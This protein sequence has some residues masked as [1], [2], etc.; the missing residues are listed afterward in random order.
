MHIL[1]QPGY[2]EQEFDEFHYKMLIA[3]TSKPEAV[4]QARQT[5]FKHY[6]Y[7]D[8]AHIDDRYGIDVDDFFEI[9]DILL[10]ADKLNYTVWVEE[11]SS[12]LP[13]DKIELGYFKLDEL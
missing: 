7:N 2:K 4:K 1:H 10:P 8:N 6:G 11:S 3:A 12:E 13:V 9:K 5:A